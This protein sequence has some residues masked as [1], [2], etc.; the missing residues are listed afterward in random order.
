MT[1]GQL[2]SRRDFGGAP[3]IAVLIFV[4]AT[5]LVLGSF[6]M[7]SNSALQKNEATRS[8]DFS[9]QL[10]SNLE[11][12][13]SESLASY[14]S[15]TPGPAPL[16]GTAI[17]EASEKTISDTAQVTSV[18]GSNPWVVTLDGIQYKDIVVAGARLIA[19]AGTGSLGSNGCVVIEI[20]KGNS[21][22]CTSTGTQPA[23]GSVTNLKMYDYV[24]CA[25]DPLSNTSSTGEIS[26]VCTPFDGSG[27]GTFYP[28]DA[29]VLT[30]TIPSGSSLSDSAI[31]NNYGIKVTGSRAVNI[32]NSV[33]NYSDAWSGKI[34]INGDV[35]VPALSS[36]S[37]RKTSGITYSVSSRAVSNGSP[38]VV[39]V[40]LSKAHDITVGE[41][42]RVTGQGTT[43]SAS[44]CNLVTKVT[45]IGANSIS[46]IQ[47]SCDPNPS[48]SS[49]TLTPI[50]AICINY[51]TSSALQSLTGALIDCQ[52]KDQIDISNSYYY[53]ALQSAVD[54]S[55]KRVNASNLVVARGD[56]PRCTGLTITSA[57]SA[58]GFDAVVSSVTTTASNATFMISN[59]SPI[60][61]GDFVVI[62]GYQNVTTTVNKK[63]TTDEW[64]ALNGEWAIT[65]KN[66]DP[67]TRNAVAITIAKPN[68]A[69]I[70]SSYS[71]SG[72]TAKSS[73]SNG[74]SIVTLNV[75]GTGDMVAGV[76]DPIVVRNLSTAING[77]L[78]LLSSRSNPIQKQSAPIG[79][80]T[81]VLKFKYSGS[82]TQG[83]I[84][85]TSP[86]QTPALG[87]VVESFQ[88]NS[89]QAT[90]PFLTLPSGKYTFEGISSLNNL[91]SQAGSQKDSYGNACPARP[92]ISTG[93]PK[94][95]ELRMTA[96]EYFF[97]H[98]APIIWSI[99]EPKVSVVNGPNSGVVAGKSPT[100]IKA[101]K[102]SASAGKQSKGSSLDLDFTLSASNPY[103]VGSTMI[104]NYRDKSGVSGT[105]PK[106]GS[107]SVVNAGQR[108]FTIRVG[109]SQLPDMSKVDVNTLE[110]AGSYFD[111]DYSL[112]N[113]SPI[114]S[115][116]GNIS[117]NLTA[118]TLKVYDSGLLQSPNGV[119]INL[120]SNISI[121]ASAGEIK[122]CP[123]NFVSSPKVSIAG[124]FVNS[125]TAPILDFAVP[126]R[127]IL[128]GQLLAPLS[129]VVLSEASS[130]GGT[131]TIPDMML[132]GGAISRAMTISVSGSQDGSVLIQKPVYFQGSGRKFLLKASIQD[133]QSKKAVKSLCVVASVDDAYGAKPGNKLTVSSV[134]K[135]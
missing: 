25:P 81:Q 16:P 125:S 105:I 113:P 104:I 62:S 21:I 7:L 35:I 135:C 134:V 70:A 127:L 26:I 109:K 67:T 132:L 46:Y 1:I 27:N 123:I 83:T 38:K 53:K 57:S 85:V 86:S 94:P 40:T 126:A 93:N 19:N 129:S 72:I 18:Q 97:D 75:Q 91:T 22:S 80:K 101:V 6:L 50:P 78:W 122:I 128:G 89:W 115:S 100:P 96:G 117:S 69:P 14:V 4:V 32:Y 71:P 28:E 43:S 116:S 130:S 29:L 76:T 12:A 108:S 79:V 133:S 33:R 44:L 95:F 31:G 68:K 47:S 66:E 30:G 77:K 48:F 3:L 121:V 17:L 9:A 107:A 118:S 20:L 56:F 58:L 92:L 124:S 23:T 119:Q 73:G 61:I 90:N 74:F 114:S 34:R 106:T 8:D 41:V 98:S 49:V 88:G 112:A 42:I 63:T 51:N 45:A 82:M 59:G 5:S 52:T 102:M 103:P 37:T 54:E 99:N 87:S 60:D 13:L 36:S 111:C 24:D 131:A 120:S 15:A 110:V 84:S 39:T 10:E 55:I 65:A 2:K 64:S 11:T